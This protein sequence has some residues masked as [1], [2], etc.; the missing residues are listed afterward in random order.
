MTTRTPPADPCA[1]CPA[2]AHLERMGIKMDC[3]FKRHFRM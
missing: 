1:T 2:Y 3:I